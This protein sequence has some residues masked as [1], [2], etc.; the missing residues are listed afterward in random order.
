MDPQL[1]CSSQSRIQSVCTFVDLSNVKSNIESCSLLFQTKFSIY[2]IPISDTFEYLQKANCKVIY[3]LKICP[4]PAS[5]H[6]CSNWPR[7][8]YKLNTHFLKGSSFW[9]RL[10]HVFLVDTVLEK[11]KRYIYKWCF[12]KWKPPLY[13]LKKGTHSK[14]FLETNPKT[15]MSNQVSHYVPRIFMYP[16]LYLP[17]VQKYFL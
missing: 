16:L 9:E 8:R 6:V 1:S 14:N 17:H 11:Y 13:L 15:C 12:H 3:K 4:W 2:I 7:L 10:K 5:F